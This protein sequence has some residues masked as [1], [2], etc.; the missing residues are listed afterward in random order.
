VS[1]FFPDPAAKRGKT[2]LTVTRLTNKQKRTSDLIRAMIELPEEWGLDIVGTG[3]DRDML[4]R[5][6]S[7][8]G[9]SHRVRF[10][11]FL[12]RSE[13]RAFLRRCGVYAMPSANEAVA[14]AVLEAMACGAAVVL[15]R[16]R[17]FEQLI[18]DGANGRLV[19]VGDIRGLAAGILD[20]W[21]HRELLG[22][23]ATETV[24]TRYNTQVLYSELAQALRQSVRA[25]RACK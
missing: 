8:L 21:E 14:L 25:H 11:G 10:H 18:A 22:G 16:I 3:P 1:E 6:A 12:G 24:R 23:A 15:S 19:S 13:V 4:Q 20:A 17:A 2:I 7:D 5:L 9:L